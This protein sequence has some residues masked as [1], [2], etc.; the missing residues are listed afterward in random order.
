MKAF[1]ILAFGVGVLAAQGCT[2]QKA[3][4]PTADAAKVS[5][6]SH[7][8]APASP[9]DGAMA[10]AVPRGVAAPECKSSDHREPGDACAPPA[11]GPGST[12]GA[13]ISPPAHASRSDESP[14]TSQ[15][16]PSAT[17]KPEPR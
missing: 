3:A 5:T 14:S 1:V 2:T 9:G 10:G 4:E 7:P 8:N 16:D 12:S 15:D 6:T 17:Q 11:N 13:E